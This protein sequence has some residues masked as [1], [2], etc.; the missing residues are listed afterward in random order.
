MASYI[1]RLSRL[2]SKPGS[3]GRQKPKPGLKRAGDATPPARINVEYLAG[4]VPVVRRRVAIAPSFSDEAILAS[5]TT[6]ASR[7][8]YEARWRAGEA[9]TL[10]LFLAS[11]GK[12]LKAC[13]TTILTLLPKPHQ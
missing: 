7:S 4:I 5:L 12:D 9:S 13:L 11:H 10:G 1:P 2:A 3:G 8:T 6:I